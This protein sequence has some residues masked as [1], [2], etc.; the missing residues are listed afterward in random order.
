MHIK[1]TVKLDYFES[2]RSS[3]SK[4]VMINFKKLKTFVNKRKIDLFMFIDT[5]TFQ[6]NLQN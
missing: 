5:S 6:Y 4:W 3:N 2:M 1:I